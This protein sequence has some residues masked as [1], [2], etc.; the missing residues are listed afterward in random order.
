MITFDR[1]DLSF[2][3]EMGWV[4]GWSGHEATY[5]SRRA[6]TSS[7]AQRTLCSAGPFMSAPRQLSSSLQLLYSDIVVYLGCRL[8]TK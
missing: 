1:K 3:F 8:I 6:E 5:P 2:F 7:E 4:T